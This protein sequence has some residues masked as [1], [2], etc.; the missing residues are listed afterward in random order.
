MKGEWRHGET[1][2][3]LMARTGPTMG[4]AVRYGEHVIAAEYSSRGCYRAMVYFCPKTQEEDAFMERPLLPELQLKEDF[5]DS[6][7]AIL[8]AIQK[9]AETERTGHM[10]DGWV[11]YDQGDYG[12]I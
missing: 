4:A 1:I 11:D 7:H 10:V 3:G 8:A 9:L 2:E 6:G 12:E 5:T